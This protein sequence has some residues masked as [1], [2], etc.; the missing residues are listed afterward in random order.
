MQAWKK[1][2]L[3]LVAIVFISPLSLSAVNLHPNNFT[4]PKRNFTIA[5]EQSDPIK[6]LI[7]ERGWYRNV[8]AAIK[9]LPIPHGGL[10]EPYLNECQEVVKKFAAEYFKNAQLLDRRVY[11][12]ILNASE[13][14]IESQKKAIRANF[15]RQNRPLAYEHMKVFRAA[16]LK[17]YNYYAPKSEYDILKTIYPSVA[18]EWKSFENY[19]H[20]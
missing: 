2:T 11:A 17:I 7:K 10:P 1:I 16:I 3:T 14:A 19:W 20:R 12:E 4:S 13:D 9:A 15:M 18:A 6:F 5:L 8:E